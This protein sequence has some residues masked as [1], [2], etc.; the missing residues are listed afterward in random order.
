MGPAGKELVTLAL[1][2][3]TSPDPFTRYAVAE[4]VDMQHRPGLCKSNVKVSSIG[5]FKLCVG[6]LENV[7]KE[8]A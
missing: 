1:S 8:V 4:L 7:S 2:K 6:V 3:S 5:Y